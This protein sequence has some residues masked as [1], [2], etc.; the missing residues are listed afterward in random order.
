M[1]HSLSLIPIPAIYQDNR[2]MPMRLLAAVCLF[3]AMGFQAANA[4]PIVTFTSQN[5]QN[6]GQYFFTLT[7]PATDTKN[8]KDLTV[9]WA[10]NVAPDA[11]IGTPNQWNPPAMLQA[12]TVTWETILVNS[13][14]V[15]G[16]TLAGF[17]IEFPEFQFPDSSKFKAVASYA[18]GTFSAQVPVNR[19]PE[20]PSIALVAITLAALGLS[21]RKL[22]GV[23]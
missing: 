17:G 8:I 9:T 14:L 20:P 1:R 6:K 13:Q 4:M 19:A 11:I 2:R 23:E 12:M 10:T 5:V 21:R 22:K 7:N 18:D 15:P 16:N 3:C